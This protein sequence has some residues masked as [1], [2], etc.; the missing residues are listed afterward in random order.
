MADGERR[1]EGRRGEDI[2]RAI[3]DR[4]GGARMLRKQLMKVFP[5]HWSFLLGE[6]ALYSFIVLLLTGIF[7]TF[8]F[9]PSMSELVYKGSYARLRGMKMSEA[10]AST[11]RISFDVRGGLLMR[12]IHHWAA[13]IFVAAI[14]IHMLRI[15]FTGAFRKPRELNWVIGVTLLIL[16]IAEGF[17]GY[18]LPDDLLSGTG[19]R[20]AQGFV[21]SFPVVG[22]YLTFFI[23][24]GQFPGHDII[25][26][27]YPVHIL[28]IPG[29]ILALLGVHLFS[30]WHQ[31][32]TQ[33]STGKTRETNVV[34]VPMY[35]IFIAK[36]TALLFFNMAVTTLLATFAQ[37]NAIWLYG[38]YSPDRVSTGAQ[39]DWYMG[40]IEGALR[41][42]PRWE[43]NVAG[44]TFMLNIFMPSVM[45]PVAFF[46]A[47]VAYPF[48]EAWITG[49]TYPHHICDRPRDVPARAGIG[50]AAVTFF[51]V[52]TAAGGND[53]LAYTL[54]VP[55]EYTT[56]FFRVTIVV[57]P[58]VAAWLVRR[59]CLG[60][61]R[62]EVTRL[63][64]GLET[65]VVNW[66]PSG[67]YVEV[68]RSP[69]D[70]AWTAAQIS[71]DGSRRTRPV[72]PP[73]LFTPLRRIRRRLN[74]RFAATEPPPLP[75]A[76]PD[77]EPEGSGTEA[78]AP[79]G[80]QPR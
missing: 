79:D 74:R 49:D 19:L 4:F 56:W 59:I 26:R 65:G 23:F 64:T 12:Q 36:T 71:R 1:R 67:E 15:F 21:Q 60:L 73:G 16:A 52:L 20:I 42:W 43:V 22:T 17:C 27:L 18:S 69:D 46:I 24:G 45:L 5:D 14:M 78:T 51:A 37:I 66:L 8:F 32:H 61:Q 13:D 31:E 3:D 53:V 70:T 6:M 50:A 75:E 72:G 35:P 80:R 44:H 11:L 57:F 76:P 25:P 48:I 38:P 9:D 33:R 54:E 10:Y 29:L 2:A 55:L 28:L 41:I 30:V 47:I 40:W 34:G 7:L 39:P 58:F 62:H 63:R 68:I 77:G